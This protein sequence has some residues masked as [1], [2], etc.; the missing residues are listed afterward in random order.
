M[1]NQLPTPQTFNT[2]HLENKN[3]IINKIKENLNYIYIALMVIVNILLGLLTIE[4]GQIGTMFPTSTLGWV[5]WGFQIAL[6]VL[7]GVLILG[8]FRRQGIKLG[9]D[10]IKTVYNKYLLTLS[11]N[12]KLAPRSLSQYMKGEAAKDM[13]SKSIVYIIIS[14]FTCSVVIGA[15]LNNILSLVIN[16][17]FAIGFGIKALLD[18]EDFVVTELV[19]WYQQKIAEVT[20]Q[21]KTEPAKEKNKN[22]SRVQRTKQSRSRSTKSSGVQQKKKCSTRPKISKPRGEC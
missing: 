1:E 10:Y 9:H 21:T 11:Q 3:K 20:D 2:P 13:S 17:I 22:E 14:I 4:D 19:V 5:L 8:A 18:A 12:R 6:Q 15:N 16:I 7:I